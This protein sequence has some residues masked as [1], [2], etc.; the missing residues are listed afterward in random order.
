[1]EYDLYKILAEYAP[2]ARTVVAED[3]QWHLADSFGGTWCEDDFDD[4]VE[5]Q[6]ATVEGLCPDCQAA[7][8]E[9]IDDPEVLEL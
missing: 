1:M 3:D 7:L 2:S 4:Q 9:E 6:D 5:V 8:V